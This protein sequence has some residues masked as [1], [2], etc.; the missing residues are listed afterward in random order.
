MGAFSVNRLPH[1]LTAATARDFVLNAPLPL[2][3]KVNSPVTDGRFEASVNLFGVIP[4][5]KTNVALAQDHYVILGGYPFGIKMMAQGV[6]VVGFGSV[7]TENGLLNPAV[8]AG[9]KEGD[10]VLAMDGVTVSTNARLQELV[11][12]SKGKPIALSVQRKGKN[13]QLTLQPVRCTDGVYR[14]GMWVRDSAAG[15]GTM[16]FYHPQSGAYGGLGHSVCDSDTGDRIS[17]L[18]GEIVSAKVLD[19]QPAKSGTPGAIVGTIS[20]G[21]TLG[22]IRENKDC[23]VFGTLAKPPDGGQTLRVAHPQEV[24]TGDATLYCSVE[25]APRAYACRIDKIVLN[26]ATQNLIVTVTDTHLLSLTGGIVQGMSGSPI[27][28]NG[29]LVGAVTHVF[30]NTPQKGYGVFAETMLESACRAAANL[31]QAS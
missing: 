15:L 1:D 13:L 9:L 22:T 19:V 20:A 4:I 25:G 28:Q 2:V 29:L 31:Q 12:K 10:V 26:H 5:A 11:A 23:G 6:M 8:D 3:A 16:T 18:T 24:K 27:V 14:V 30:V 17:L 21:E 7:Q